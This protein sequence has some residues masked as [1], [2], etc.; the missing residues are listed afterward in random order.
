LLW[1]VEHIIAPI[2]MV[3]PKD[4]PQVIIGLLTIL[5]HFPLLGKNLLDVLLSDLLLEL[6]DFLLHF[7]FYKNSMLNNRVSDDLLKM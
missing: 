1:G 4:I 5:D 6:H 7:I 2:S 3:L